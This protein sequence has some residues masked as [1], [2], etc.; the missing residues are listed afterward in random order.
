MMEQRANDSKQANLLAYVYLHT[1]QV[2]YYASFIRSC[3]VPQSTSS[4]NSTYSQLGTLIKLIQEA[5][6]P[7]AGSSAS[8]DLST[9]G[10]PAQFRTTLDKRSCHPQDNRWCIIDEGSDF[11]GSIKS[12][13]RL[14]DTTAYVQR[15]SSRSHR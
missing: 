9:C 13:S 5:H 6:S 12:K 15:S 10:M 4:P 2:L 8:G 3:T 1:L 11:K 7:S 14:G